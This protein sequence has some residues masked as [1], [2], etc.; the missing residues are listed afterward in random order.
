MIFPTYDINFKANLNDNS[1]LVT[2]EVENNSVRDYS[3]AMFRIALFDKKQR[4][5]TGFAKVY[6]FK[7]NT[8]KAFEAQIKGAEATAIPS[9]ARYEILFETG[10]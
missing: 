8:R 9:I 7:K 1:L 2:G 3:V 4:L 10:Y 5:G 6:E